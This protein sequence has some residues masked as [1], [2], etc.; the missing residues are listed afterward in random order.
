MSQGGQAG[1]GG[2]GGGSNIQTILGDVGSI[3]GQVVTIFADTPIAGASVRFLN[4]GTIS[5]FQVTDALTNTFV[6]Q[7]AGTTTVTGGAN[8]GF[9][10][11]A[12]FSITS[13]SGNNV[14]GGAGGFNLTTGSDNCFFGEGVA[15]SLISGSGNIIIGGDLHGQAYTSSESNNILISNIGV[16]AESNVMRL[17]TT[18]SGTGQINKS[19]LAGTVG[20]TITA[21]SVMT[22]D[23]STEQTS[24]DTTNFKILSTGLQL[25]GNNTNTSP[26]AGFIGE[27]IQ[28]V[29]PV[30]GA[31]SV[32]LINNSPVNITSL[33]LLPGIYDLTGIVYFSNESGLGLGNNESA[34]ISTTSATQPGVGA[35]GD[36]L[37]SG[38]PLGGLQN[39]TL[40]IPNYRMLIGST[41]TVYLSAQ[42]TITAGTP[43][44]GG[45]FS[46]VRVG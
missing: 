40:Q 8:T 22:I 35:Y 19:F 32:T 2:G 9:G 3:T 25:K 39:N 28:S 24:N 34:W 37:V 38:G 46:A 4:S 26:P 27:H 43:K 41:T 23:T 17:G 5:Q 29:V 30:T 16:I 21:P 1:N 36:S 12:L 20:T 31:G 44:G 15:E 45:R 6:G 13:G 7:N 10:A 11:E 42:L 14:F 33:S 18:G